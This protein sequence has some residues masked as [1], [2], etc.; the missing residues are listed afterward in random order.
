MEVSVTVGM[1]N[2]HRF[3]LPQAIII[4][5]TDREDPFFVNSIKS[6][7]TELG[8]SL[9]ELPFAGVE[10]MMWI[11]RLDSGSLSGKSR[12]LQAMGQLL[13]QCQHGKRHMSIYSSMHPQRHQVP[14]SDSSGLSK[15]LIT[16]AI[17]AHTSQ[18]SFRQTLM[19]PRMIS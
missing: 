4:D 15:R 14:L 10:K 16:L 12:L 3:V 8:T 9:I 5:N 13:I 19:H 6:K 2:I 18:S 11:S 17:G 7:A 1:A